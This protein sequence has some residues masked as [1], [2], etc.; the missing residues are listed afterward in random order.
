MQGGSSASRSLSLVIWYSVRIYSWT[1]DKNENWHCGARR[2]IRAG[3]AGVVAWQM[4]GDE[5]E[6]VSSGQWVQ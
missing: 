4:L 6:I 5:G 3:G 1:R 2:N